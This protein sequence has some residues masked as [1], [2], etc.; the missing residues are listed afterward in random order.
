MKLISDLIFLKGWECEKIICIF[1]VNAEWNL[2]G[3]ED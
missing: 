1:N 2:F 3:W